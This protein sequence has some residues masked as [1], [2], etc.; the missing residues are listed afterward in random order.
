MAQDIVAKIQAAAQA[1]GVDPDVALRI[2]NV[3]SNLRPG[4][5]NPKS[6]AAG[7]FQVTDDTWKQY[8]GQPGKKRDVDENIR[9]GMDI[10]SSNKASLAQSLGREP[11]ASEIYAAH[12][13]GPTGAKRVLAADPLTPVS[14]LV[15][16]KVLAANP[17]LKGKTVNE[18]LEGYRQK[19]DEGGGRYP[20]SEPVRTT[21]EQA[22]RT[23][24]QEAG[25]VAPA[26]PARDR[27]ASLGANYQAAL[28]AMMLAEATDD[29]E[30]DET[31]VVAR[32]TPYE[33]ASARNA[34]AELDLGAT[35]SPFAAMEPQKFAEGGPVIPAGGAFTVSTVDPVLAPVPRQDDDDRTLEDMAQ[36]DDS[37]F[38]QLPSEILGM[39]ISQDT[40]KEAALQLGLTAVGL[41]PAVKAYNQLKQGAKAALGVYDAATGQYLPQEV[42][43][44]KLNNA[45]IPERLPKQAAPVVSTLGP[46]TSNLAIE[47]AVEAD[48]IANANAAA[49][50]ASQGVKPDAFGIEGAAVTVPASGSESWT[51]S[52][53]ETS[54]GSDSSVSPSTDRGFDSSFGYGMGYAEGGEVEDDTPSIFNLKDYA[55]RKAE[56]MYPN[57][58]GQDDARDAARHL[59]AA[60]TAARKYGPSAAE[61]LG[62]LYER[63]SNP[64][65][66]FS[67]F[68]IGEPRGDYVYDTHNNT[69]GVELGSRA[70]S[71]RE[72][73]RLVK[74]MTELSSF[75]KKE[76]RPWIM[77]Q[78]QM[79]EAR[80]AARA[81][82][83]KMKQTPEGYADGGDVA[84]PEYALL[85]GAGDAPP[86][87]VTDAQAALALMRGVGD[88][89]Y[90]L[91]GAPV[92]IS[93]LIMSPTGKRTEE[94]SSDWIKKKAT[95]LGIR[96][97][98]ETDPTLA[99]LR[100]LGEVGASSINPASVPRAAAR[101]VEM[102][103]AAAKDLA[104]SEPARVMLEKAMAAG[105]SGP[106][107]A[108][109]PPGGYMLQEPAV[110]SPSGK[111][112]KPAEPAL[113]GV[114][115]MMRTA[116]SDLL[117]NATPDSERVNAVSKFLMNQGRQYFAKNYASTKDPIY[118][119]LKEGRIKPL[120][121]EE[122]AFRSYMLNAAREGDPEATEDFA[123][124]Y[125]A[126]LRG[127]SVSGDTGTSNMRQAEAL[128]EKTKE[129]GKQAGLTPADISQL[130]LYQGPSTSSVGELMAKG[131][132][133][134]QAAAKYGDPVFDIS[135]YNVP[136][137]M[138]PDVLVDELLQIP[139]E[140]LEKMSYPEAVIAAN[141]NLLFKADYDA[142]VK[143]VYEG[144]TVP[145]EVMFFGTEKVDTTSPNKNLQWYQI[146]DSKAT[147]MEGRSMGHSVHNYSEYN[148]YNEG[149][150][151]AFD[152]GRALIYS[153][154]D[155][156]GI[157]TTTVEVVKRKD[158]DGNTITGITDIRGKYNSRPL[159]DN[160][161]F[162][163]FDEVKPD[164]ILSRMNN[165]T[166][167]RWF[168]STDNRN[169]R[170][171]APVVVDWAK[172]Y[173]KYKTGDVQE[174]AKGGLVERNVYN[175]QK[176]L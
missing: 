103:G 26:L 84:D 140:K 142:A 112:F 141:K 81:K 152:E 134:L 31:G 67:T 2:A 123:K 97:A 135:E 80:D 79:D 39:P 9:V 92:D 62:Q 60:G 32:E 120:K 145:K 154:R 24:D 160:D 124:V 56:E 21:V 164:F 144:K 93:N 85:A 117:R 38:S 107:Y 136:R 83:L 34:L 118:D 54:G 155:K 119:A 151:A 74:E 20:T 52:G 7:L 130:Y 14:S 23:M 169:E 17:Q 158:A 27:V 165:E 75:E 40:Y 147:A 73:E 131:V 167:S 126:G 149:G 139:P 12:F 128:F 113:A 138:R 22:P 157:P 174:F 125:D 156:E 42:D 77:S 70:K 19:F 45:M 94:M 57:M 44:Y 59:L 36:D 86:P 132:P 53:G 171:E 90:V 10:L 101:G 168:Y 28:A 148:N 18:V 63:T 173:E 76:G 146:K 37:I 68:G 49:L 16:K 122:K 11:L 133:E 99:G 71:Q 172:E 96:P 51:R 8:G 88:L 159:S 166:N 150:K 65:T 116:T 82:L 104:T 69:V 143:R 4:A 105:G 46:D 109:R 5:K 33:A 115:Q 110:V 41:G 106:M 108:V 121:G 47:R 15:S 114:D 87:R 30:K 29:E 162:A 55:T 175:H 64:E 6:S 25:A 72:L 111:L 170:L 137:F 163:L 161:L 13:F 1:S 91:A 98:D 3:E 100:M 48:R 129:A 66:L 127:Y 58:A 43:V 153:L 61:M 50:L 102:A 95:E 89:P 35:V 176:Y 78:E